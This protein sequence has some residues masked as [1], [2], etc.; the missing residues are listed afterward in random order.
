MERISKLNLPTAFVFI[1]LILNGSIFS[2][3]AKDWT[4]LATYTIPGKASGLASDGNFIYFGIY[5]SEGDHIYKFDPATGNNEL[6]FTNNQI[7]DCYG[8]TSDGTSLYM[9]DHVTSPSVPAYAMQF[10]LTGNLLS[11]FDL[12]DHY[13]SGI[14]Y[15]NGDFWVA[16]YYPDPGTIYKVDNSGAVLS[17]FTSPDDQPWDLC[18]EGSD[19][20]VADYNANMLYKTDQSGNILESHESE[21][22]KPAGVVFDGQYLWYV[23][24]GLN[25]NST[26]YKV[27]LGGAGT[28]QIT[29]PVTNYNYGN[30]AV[31]D[32]A[33]WN[34]VVQ[35][36]GTADLEITNIVVQ[37]AVPVFYYMTFP[38]TI[39]PGDFIE[40][41]LIYK[42]AEPGNLNTTV[43]IESNDIINPGVD[44]LLEGNA[45][46]NGPHIIVSSTSHDYGNVR[47]NATTR[48]F[49]QVE[50][51]GNQQ[52]EITGI[53][54]YTEDFYIDP[55]IS[56]PIYINVLQTVD[57]GFWFNP[58]EAGNLSATAIISHN[59][60]SQDP[61][62]VSLSGTGIE[63]DYPIG[64]ELWNYTISGGYDNS[65]KA[66]APLPDVSGDGIADVIVCSEDDFVRCF[67]GNSNG[68]ADVLWENE[69]GTVYSQNG[70]TTIEDINNDGYNDVIVGLA[71]GVR[72]IKALSGKTGNQIWMYDTHIFGDGGW[73]YQV[74]T[75]FDYNDDGITDVH[76][77]TGNDGYNSGPKRFFCLDGTNGTPLWD[78][79][80]D[81]PNFA[82]M[83]VED[84]TGDGKPDVVGGSSDNYETQGIVY[85][86]NG[87]NGSIEWSFNANGTSVW[88]VEQLDDFTGDGI[89]DITAGDF[90]GSFYLIDATNGAA[91]YSGSVGSNLILR[92]ERLDDVNGDGYADIAIAQSGTS[93]VVFSGY[94]AQN[95]WLQSL[96]DKAWNIDRIA[97]ISGD[98]INDVITGTLYTNNRAYFLDGVTGA[99][100]ESVFYGEAIDAIAAIPD[101]TGDG[102]MEMV[103]GGRNGLLT[104]FSG[105]LN[106]S[107]LSADFEANPTS[108]S[109]PL[110]VQFSDLSSGNVTSW[111][112]DF[113]NDGVFDSG[114]QNPVWT[115]EDEGYFTVKLIVSDGTDF[116]TAVKTDY[117]Y[118]DT[119]TGITHLQNINDIA[120]SPNPFK[121]KTVIG[122]S[123]DKESEI[124]IS[125]Y[126]LTGKMIKNL[127]DKE[128]YQPGRLEI[129]WDRTNSVG[130]KTKPGLYL[131]IINVNDRKTIKKII[132][133]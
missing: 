98:G 18:L 7:N 15:D 23:D 53:D 104:C 32:S 93:A 59:D 110:N 20:W 5:G 65:I 84:F 69:A 116:D 78:T 105:G 40:I 22:V 9:T 55:D 107:A 6:L 97:D 122:L 113:N 111:Q 37:N 76:A 34:C 4:I 101:I 128:A 118:V 8:L 10:D 103:A 38:Q 33:V 50:N 82:V 68:I 64:D 114:E 108:G 27:D 57:I 115:Y 67:N 73:V 79:Y 66:I 91:Q 83:G 74:W 35:N 96:P 112:W 87:S 14:A 61:I 131:C 99:E 47:I 58:G 48:W 46:F 49:L 124:S 29:V 92:F 100:L 102:S 26:L 77:A 54:L 130:I 28:P 60:N 31:G 25:T 30:I 56:F 119:L 17:Q 106:S 42:P 45:V 19:I 85:G 126:D 39:S 86:I 1:L 123:L 51:N 88:A 95:I 94:N 70:I 24:G 21:N 132:A 127:I 41:P 3:T 89:K 75:G 44:L 125:I 62:S 109:A 120:I 63:Q 129:I 80:T 2:Q 90:A 43:V 133:E 13:M 81:G 72:A 36:T 121:N 52:L 71:W 16:T 11:Q 117:I 12:P